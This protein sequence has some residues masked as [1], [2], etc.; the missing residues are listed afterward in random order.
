MSYVKVSRVSMGCTAWS[1]LSYRFMSTCAQLASTRKLLL[2]PAI[3]DGVMTV[4]VMMAMAVQKIMNKYVYSMYIFI[5]HVRRAVTAQEQCA[6]AVLSPWS[7]PEEP[8]GSSVEH[9]HTSDVP[10]VTAYISPARATCQ[11]LR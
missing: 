8:H 10:A 7:R 6:L 2:S 9:R 11:V 1:L 5:L 4:L 3:Y